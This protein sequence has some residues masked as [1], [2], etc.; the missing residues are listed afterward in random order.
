MAARLTGV[1][2]K[3]RAAAEPLWTRVSGQ[4]AKQYETL[5][6]K[7]AQYVVKDKEAA[8]KL[9]KQYV[10]TQLARIPTG[11]AECS[12]EA[13]VMRQKWANLRELPA[14]EVAT[15]VGFAAEL[16]AWFCLGEI[17][18]RGGTLTGYSV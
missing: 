4:T 1:L 16:Y 11:M 8:D 18:G 13:A 5:M 3:A 2:S 14:T 12:R 10:F 9:L 17:V 7:N 6:A 15:Y